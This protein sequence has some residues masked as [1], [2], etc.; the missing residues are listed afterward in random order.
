MG[1]VRIG[2][3][4][5]SGATSRSAVL[6]GGVDASGFSCVV[7]SS[8]N[9]AASVAEASMV[10]GSAVTESA[11]AEVRVRLAV[12]SGAKPSVVW[13]SPAQLD[14]LSVGV[15][16]CGFAVSSCEISCSICALN[17]FEARLNSFDHLPTVR[18]ISGNFLGPKMMRARKNRKMVSPTH[19][20]IIV[21]E[22]ER[23]QLR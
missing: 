1:V 19:S 9:G 12:P 8:I 6:L 17:S 5:L 13:L 15:R 14:E 16:I 3:S 23:R 22:A 10:A 11:F 7:E 20:V 2:N 4:V 18:A 21:Q